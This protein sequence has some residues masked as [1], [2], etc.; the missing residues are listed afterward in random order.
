[1]L[2]DSTNPRPVDATQGFAS[3]SALVAFIFTAMVTACTISPA[4]GRNERSKKAL[5]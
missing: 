2:P 5:L 1:M 4:A 3:K